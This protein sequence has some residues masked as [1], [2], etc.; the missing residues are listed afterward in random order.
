MG[1][2]AYG[3]FPKSVAVADTAIKLPRYDVAAAN[4]LLDSLGWKVGA[5]SVRAKNGRK[6]EFGLLVPTSSRARM[7]YSVLLQEQF[8]RVGAKVNLDQIEIN[9]MQQRLDTRNFDAA[10]NAYNT[11]PSPGGLKQS[12]SST[13]IGAAGGNVLSYKNTQVDAL[14]DSALASFDMNKTKQYASRAF[15]LIADD[16]PAIWLY[17]LVNVAGAH[18]RLQITGLRADGWWNNL[19]DWS[20]PADQRIDRDRLGLTAA[21]R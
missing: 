18:R 3:P 2:P 16:A 14:L 21:N 6:L 13:G 20:I 7:S 12:W 10:L 19:A 9:A 8:K 15:Q 5:D 17:D 4:A 1:Q 11:D